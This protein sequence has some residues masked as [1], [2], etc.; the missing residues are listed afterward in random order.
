MLEEIGKVRNKLQGTETI[1]SH[2]RFELL[3]CQKSWVDNI[4]EKLAESSQNC[5]DVRKTKMA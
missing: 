5:R 2:C 4:L 3:N 1:T